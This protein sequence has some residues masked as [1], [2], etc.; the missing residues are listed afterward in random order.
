MPSPFAGMDPY[1]ES[2]GMWSD[3]HATLVPALRAQLNARLPKQFV[4]SIE[5]YVW[6]HEPEVRKRRQ[7]EPDLYV[8]ERSRR[9][10][11]E[12]VA[13]AKAAPAEISLPLTQRR[14]RK[15]IHITD[16][17]SR[18]VVTAI[19]IVS[20]SNKTPGEDRE[21][22]LVK[23][24]EYL[25][26]NLSFVEIDLLRGG[27]RLPLSMPPPPIRD[28]YVLVCRSWEFPRAGLWTFGIRDPIPEI[29]IPLAADVPDVPLSLHTGV[30]RA[31]EEGRYDEEL[32]YHERLLPPVNRADAAWIREVL[33]A[34]HRR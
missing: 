11:G 27:K 26:S 22:Y 24:G 21:A 19:E 4:A 25:A 34:R 30:D 28:Y 12:A 9:A 31:Y 15:L 17:H 32:R 14:K 2:S 23:R 6:F 7:R 10:A 20:P 13:T 5:L 3:F 8:V 29:P 18:R 16:V 1:I 33:A